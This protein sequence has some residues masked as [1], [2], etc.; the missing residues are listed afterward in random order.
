MATSF[1][2]ARD[3]SSLSVRDLL[4]ARDTY[5]LHLAH[6]ENVV[7]TAIGRFRIRNGD[8]DATRPGATRARAGRRRTASKPRTL[9]ETVV[10]P[11]SWPA[12]LVFVN[13]WLTPA[14]WRDR[15]D[16]VVPSFLYMPDGRVVPTCVIYVGEREAAPAQDRVFSFPSDL[17]GGGYPVL[18]D[19][20]GEERVASLACMV[21]DGDGI[22][23]LT[24]RHVAGEEGRAIYSLL[25]G[26]RQKIG[27][28]HKQQIGK[29]PFPRA[30]PG[31]PGERVLAN[32]DAGLIRVEEIGDWTAQVFGIG[33]IG[34]PIN[35]NTDTI[36]LDLIGCPVRAFG[37]ASGLLTGEIQALFYRYRSIGG[38]DYAADML[39]GPRE[40]ATLN[41]RPG[42]SGTLWFWD[43]AEKRRDDAPAPRLRPLA[44]QWGGDRLLGADGEAGMGFALA[45]CLST[46][47]RELDVEVIGDWQIGQREYWGKL[48]HFKVGAAAC[49]L[50][51]P[52]KLQRLIDAN[53]DRIGF[54]D[55]DIAAEEFDH[56][57][58]G[59]FVP[60]ADVADLV[61]RTTRKKDEGNHFADMDEPGNGE[62]ANQTLL[63]V[64]AQVQ[65]VDVRVWNRFYDSLHIGAKRGAL[66]FRVWQIYQEM[67]AFAGA[68]K[69]AEFLCAA[70]IL[71]HYI[72]DA[73][74]P[75]HVSRLHHGRPGFDEGDVHSVYEDTMLER[76]SG[77]L[78]AGIGGALQ[79]VLVQ[80]QA[81]G[82]R[83]AA[84]AAIELMRDTV[85][86]LP[87]MEVIDAYNG[88]SGRARIPHMWDVVGE[89]TI[90]CIARGC[91][92]LAEIWASAWLE[93]HGDDI[94]E[95]QLVRIDT[96][97]L[98]SLYN[99]A[100]FLP[101]LRLR[102][103]E[104][105][106]VL[107]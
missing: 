93:G 99:N 53:R 3:F 67:V 96:Q 45:T 4:E 2:P 10:R 89:R 35:L 107:H 103:M 37:S 40:G 65:N 78:L 104:A 1:P 71:A 48:G 77:E 21:T 32:L 12:V 23:A 59:A 39:I 27:N 18:A 79:G 62:F 100:A 54:S 47:C 7:A 51:S 8:P 74:Q 36:S 9:Q 22:Y 31:W 30:Y 5:H 68:G 82:G 16:Q 76:W 52:G 17:I 55:A 105:Q 91:K 29:L 13:K 102:E 72:G 56:I 44:L 86:T 49:G 101:A 57:A 26:Q 60:L 94:G 25:R 73:C 95:A 87:P 24:N 28:S 63:D 15:P 92:V 58:R 38:T 61:W 97:T 41:T 19:V 42:D 46:I 85:A 83:G 106:N 69:V 14:E 11:W 33:E 98:M 88:A 75:L 84:V 70:G 80:G 81:I 90:V 64:C 20:Q 50:I 6:L 43:V 34:E 66:P